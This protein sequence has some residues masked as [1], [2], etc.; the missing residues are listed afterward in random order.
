MLFLATLPLEET[1][2]TGGGSGLMEL[3][4]PAVFVIAIFY[5]VL[6]LPERKKQKK[7][8]SML[9]EMKK[10]D[11]VMTTSGMF[12][13]VVQMQ[14]DS[15]TLQVADGVRL[16]FTRAAVQQTLETA[17]GKEDKKDDKK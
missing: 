4:L 14:D 12:G 2:S 9:D 11:R 7:R 1:D 10:G 3:A 5:F 8:Q 6:I 13:T 17:D 15:V 16:R